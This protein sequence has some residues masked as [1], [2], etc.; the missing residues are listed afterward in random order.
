MAE[1]GSRSFP[2]DRS[3]RSERGMIAYKPGNGKRGGAQKS[4][5][6]L[7]EQSVIF[8][9]FSRQKLINPPEKISDGMEVAQELCS[10]MDLELGVTGLIRGSR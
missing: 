1:E 9:L 10:K 8:S 6:F 2:P 4:G 5:R 7:A 3:V